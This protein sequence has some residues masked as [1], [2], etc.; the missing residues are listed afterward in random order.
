MYLS[1]KNLIRLFIPFILSFGIYFFS[2]NIIQYSKYIFTD[3]TTQK[4]EQLDQRVNLYLQIKNYKS[5]F[6]TILNNMDKCQKNIEW[7][8]S[9]FLYIYKKDTPLTT[10]K[11]K[12][13]NW[14][15]QALF[16]QQKVAIINSKI[17]HLYETVNGAKVIKITQNQAL[18]KTK[19]GHK[20]LSLFH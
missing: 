5:I 12:V 4:R 19:K 6:Q 3:T 20:W 8:N 17:V 14:T 11:K 16:P 15:L 1:N 18:L 2:D 9:K 13:Q 10:K 7:I